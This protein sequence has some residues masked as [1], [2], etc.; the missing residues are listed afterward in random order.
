VFGEII[1]SSRGGD[2]DVWGL[3]WVLEFGFIV[4]E[5]NA[6]EIATEAELRLLEVTTYISECLPSL[7]KS[8][9]I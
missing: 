9:K 5:R 8:L 7:L 1:E 4:L 6:A 3:G 2:D